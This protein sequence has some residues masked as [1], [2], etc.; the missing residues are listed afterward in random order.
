MTEPNLP[1]EPKKPN[2][3]RSRRCAA[4]GTTRL[5][6]YRNALGLGPNIASTLLDLSE[7]GLRVV[8]K[9]SATVEQEVEVNLEST[10]TGRMTKTTAIVVWVIPS[11]EGGFVVGLH[12]QKALGYSDLQALTKP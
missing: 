1:P 10:A 12:F 9:E 8:L 7:T 4:R 6:V 2:K 3:R 5:R 11:S